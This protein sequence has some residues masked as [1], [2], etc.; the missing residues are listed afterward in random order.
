MSKGFCQVRE[1][2]Q[3]A[4]LVGWQRYARISCASFLTWDFVEEQS[5]EFGLLSIFPVP[6]YV[7]DG[8]CEKITGR[9]ACLCKNNLSNSIAWPKYL[10]EYTPH[11]MNVVIANLQ[12]NGASFR[13]NIAEHDQPIA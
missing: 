1:H 5:S 9:A 4:P 10:V 7:I 3:G 13:K 2:R 11:N 12:E 6:Q 8:R